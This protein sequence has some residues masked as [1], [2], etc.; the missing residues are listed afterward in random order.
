[1]WKNININRQNIKTETSKSVLIQ[2]PH[3][4][5]YDGY[6]FWYPAK[7][8]RNGKNSNAISVAY[9]DEFVFRLKK[10]G[11]GKYNKFDVIDEEE[12]DV[13]EFEE[14][15]GVMNDNI[16]GKDEESYLIIEEPQKLEIDVEI[17]EELKN[18]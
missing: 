6:S 2:M 18:E 15:F 1:M 5:N 4:S 7:L 3:N 10:Y 17:V 11:N 8:V 9:N 14:A 16:R 12:I 13:E